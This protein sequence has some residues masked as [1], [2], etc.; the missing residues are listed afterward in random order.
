MEQEDTRAKVHDIIKGFSTAMF[1]SVGP[2]GKP[3][4]RP[5]QIAKFLEDSDEIC[6]FTGRG[7]TLA[8]EIKADSVVLLAFQNENSSYLSLRG[9]A[10]VVQ[11][12]ARIQQYWKE[13]Y[14]VWFPGGPTDPEIALV[15]VKAIDAEYWDTRGT[16][17]VEYMF[18]TVKAYVTGHKPDISQPEQ[19]GKTSL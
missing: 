8:E 19:H 7:G 18:E 16:K 6:F 3:E 1:V 17:K 13:P 4:A 5:M 11:D 14:R 10:R 12:P 15:Q 2:A 9:S